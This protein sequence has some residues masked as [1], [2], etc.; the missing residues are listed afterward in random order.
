MLIV[1]CSEQDPDAAPLAAGELCARIRT[2]AV[3]RAL[4]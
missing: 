1:Q 3:I 4:W 2:I